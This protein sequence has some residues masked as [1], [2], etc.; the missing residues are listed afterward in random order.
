MNEVVLGRMIH[1][2]HDK[3]VKSDAIIAVEPLSGLGKY[4]TT[5]GDDNKLR[6]RVLIAHGEGEL[7]A[8]RTAQTILKSMT[9]QEEAKGSS[10]TNVVNNLRVYDK[11][12]SAEEIEKEMLIDSLVHWNTVEGAIE[13]LP[14]GKTK[15]YRLLKKYDIDTRDYRN[16]TD[17]SEAFQDNIGLE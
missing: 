11:A 3:W 12:L 9:K 6:S 15:F 17:D 1:L 5:D 10:V 14:Y 4:Y 13:S 8:S 2:G 16:V 7:L